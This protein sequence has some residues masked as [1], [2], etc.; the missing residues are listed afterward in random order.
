MLRGLLRHGDT[1]L[2]RVLAAVSRSVH[3]N[4]GPGYWRVG[5]GHQWQVSGV[6]VN[7]STNGSGAFAASFHG[8]LAASVAVFHSLDRTSREVEA[9]GRAQER[10]IALIK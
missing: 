4:V 9:Q 5:H 3:R 8:G 1:Y 10:Y 6:A 7:A 2:A